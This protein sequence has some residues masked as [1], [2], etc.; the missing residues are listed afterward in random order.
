[1][2]IGSSQR[3]CLVSLS[4]Q[5]KIKYPRIFTPLR[6]MGRSFFH[7]ICFQLI[8]S[9]LYFVTNMILN[10]GLW[11]GGGSDWSLEERPSCRGSTSKN[12]SEDPVFSFCPYTRPGSLVSGEQ[13]RRASSA[14]DSSEHLFQLGGGDCAS[15][16]FSYCYHIV[17]NI[18]C[19]HL[20][21]SL[22]K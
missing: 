9:Y 21:Q 15:Y 5:L 13:G 11:Y 12:V 8:I 14:Q 20:N 18:H 6:N 3:P 4:P 7:T 2:N 16:N 17:F 1:M 19:C 22:A 10:L